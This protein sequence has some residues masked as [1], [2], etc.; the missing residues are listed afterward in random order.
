[1]LFRRKHPATDEP[2]TSQKHACSGEAE[3][4]THPANTPTPLFLTDPKELSYP[5]KGGEQPGEAAQYLPDGS[6]HYSPVSML[7]TP[8]ALVSHGD[9][10]SLGLP[11]YEMSSEGQAAAAAKAMELPTVRDPS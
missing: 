4:Q 5:D 10:E 7:N 3:D 2:P 1:M 11:E 8:V 6:V 9:D